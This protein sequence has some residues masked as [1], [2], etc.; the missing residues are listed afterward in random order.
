MSN[1]EAVNMTLISQNTLEGFGGIGEGMMIQEAKDGRRI[2]WLAHEGAPKNFTGVD[3]SDPKNLKVVVQTE[4]PHNNMRSNSLDL[5]GD[6]LA[7]AYQTM[8]PG[9]L[10]NAL[11]T[12]W[13][14]TRWRAPEPGT[15]PS[16]SGGCAARIRSNTCSTLS[17]VSTTPSVWSAGGSS[18]STVRSIR[19]PS[20]GLKCPGS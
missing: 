6:L 3:V 1:H 9:G 5:C 12:R 19:D 8:G 2:M 16:S 13:P 7:V 11:R 15:S 4:L 20:A 10:A 17:G 18:A 14:R